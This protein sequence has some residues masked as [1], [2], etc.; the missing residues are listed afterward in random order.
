MIKPTKINDLLPLRN[1]DFATLVEALDYAAEGETGYN[2]YDGRGELFAVISYRDL[3]DDARSLARKLRGLGCRRGARVAIIAETEPMFHRFFF[4]CQ[5]AGYIPVALPAGFQIGAR[6]A[7]VEQLER[8]LD[9]CG[10]DIAVAP[11]SHVGFL[12]QAVER[13]D[14]VKA[15]TPDEFD[16]LSELAC[17]LSPLRADET[18]Y[19]QYTSGSTRFPRG[20]EISQTTV[21]TNLRD[22]AVH[23][24][25]ITRQD[26][27]VS[28]L[29]LYHD[30]GLVGF[31][32][33]PLGSQLSADYLSP[34]TFAMRP[35]LWLKVISQNRGT[36]SSSPPFG[37]ALC[38]K[39]LRLTDQDRY[40][41]SSWRVACV[42][43]ERIHP[44]PLRQFA[45]VLAPAKFDAKA[46]VACYGMAECAL[47]ISFAPLD[48]GISAVRV[49]KEIMSREG[50]VQIL[51]EGKPAGPDDA[52]TFVDCGRILPSFAMAIRDDEGRDLGD[53]QCGR[54]CLKGPSVMKGYFQN[55]DATAEVLSDDGWLD[56]GDIGYRVG[57]HVVVTARRKD[58]IIVNGRNI[59][60]HDLE[61]L[62]ESLPGVRF[63]N[64]SAFSF[65][66]DMGADQVVMVVESRETNP[67]K[68]RTLIDEL[69]ALI[70]EHFGVSCHIDLVPPRT[71][72]RTSS[73]KLSRSKAKQDF[74]A[75]AECL[76]STAVGAHA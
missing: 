67:A 36:I 56:T 29:P 73:G 10:A 66:D 23:G 72:P 42:G 52:L 1:A 2:F 35:R 33:L 63:G 44:E 43:A 31:V 8:M 61:Y 32:L 59:W 12:R 54:I 51:G 21:M 17:D 58:V 74:L 13:L 4:A 22:I 3:R 49:D 30:M 14:L 6:K 5:F 7:Y 18:A 53:Y 20:C 28:W 38:A 16:A 55:P 71:L 37:Y 75:R 11:D 41:L 27:M 76:P 19:L 69:R 46:F 60:P 64:V 57:E 45:H 39:R 34:R 40:D 25:K 50:R 68:A 9:S 70:A 15:G 47:A 65:A 48:S 26:R 24:L 62:A